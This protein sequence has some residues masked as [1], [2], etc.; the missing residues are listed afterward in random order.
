MLFVVDEPDHPLGKVQVYPVAEV[1]LVTEY[2]SVA[3]A[4]TEVLPVIVDGVAGVAF[5]AT[6]TAILSDS[7]PLTVCVA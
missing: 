7:T 6:T 2:I 5:I 3:L 1:S 4:T